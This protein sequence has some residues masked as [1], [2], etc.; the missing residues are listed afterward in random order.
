MLLIPGTGSVAHLEE[1]LAA[2]EIELDAADRPT[3][4]RVQHLGDPMARKRG[5]LEPAPVDAVA[6]HDPAVHR[7]QAGV[8]RVVGLED[9]AGLAVFQAASG[10]AA[11]KCST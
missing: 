5:R 9:E 1:N 11:S 3:L 8:H 10:S 6:L 7:F 4:E 2:A